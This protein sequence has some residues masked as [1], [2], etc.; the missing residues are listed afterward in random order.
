MKKEDLIKLGVDEKTVYQIFAIH[1]K[2]LEK[3]KSSVAQVTTER[4]AL[5]TQLDETS[6]QIES[7]KNMKPEELQKAADEW[8]SKYEQATTEAQKQ[9]ANLKFDHA[10]QS[11]LS[12]AKA[13]NPKAVQA[14]L[15]KELLKLNDADGSI[16]G[17]NEQL[18]KIKSEN[19]YLFADETPA[20]KIVT[21]AKSQSI[22]GDPQMDAMRKA[23]GLPLPK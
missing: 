23:A 7:F 16:V 17:L 12:G 8:K 18:E 10:L 13:K 2:D 20:P 14:L 6:K 22:I 5:K 15:D 19:D 9:L 21:G 3:M 1:G 11:A 4:D